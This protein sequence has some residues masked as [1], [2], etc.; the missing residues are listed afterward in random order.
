MDLGDELSEATL[1]T[2]TDLKQYTYCPRVLYYQACLPD[3]RP[4]TYK[5]Q[6]GAEAGEEEQKRAARRTLSAYHV[7]EGK[8]HYDVPV[9]SYRLSLSGKVDEVVEARAPER[10]IVPV[11]YKLAKIAGQ[12]FK[13][14][15]T[16]YAEM[17]SETW[18]YPVKRGYLLLIPLRRFE[19]VTITDRLRGALQAALEAMWRITQR[20][21]TPPP[22]DNRRKCAACEFRRFCNDV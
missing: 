7:L 11:D 10:E 8:R 19:E 20:E 14:Q 15:L 5:M 22:A 18:G 1:F 13:V 4:T 21:A 12:H 3:V 2:V 17:L 6:A 16:A 9:I